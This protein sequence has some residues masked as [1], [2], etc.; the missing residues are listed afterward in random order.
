MNNENY[1]IIELDD[2]KW[3][4]IAETTYD[5]I[6]YDYVVGVNDNEDE[7]LDEYRVMKVEEYNDEL[8][9]D[10][11]TDKELLNKIM[12]LLMPEAKQFM[13]NP[14]KLKELLEK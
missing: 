6:L 1:E 9:F 5:N 14:E 12:P 7:F 3:F 8:Y 2:G 13:E 10:T 4:V 11:V